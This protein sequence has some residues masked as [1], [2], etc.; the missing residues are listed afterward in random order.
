[1]EGEM[2]RF[3]GKVAVIT[4]AATGVGR[5]LAERSAKEGMKVV[6]ADIDK[7]ALNQTAKSLE[8]A[9]ADVLAVVTDVS[10]V[11]EV[12][13]LAKK[14]LDKFGAVH[15][16]C[17]TAAV[18]YLTPLTE[19]SLADW[20]W[21]IG[22]NL[23]GHIH[24]VAVFLPTMIMQDTECHIVNTAPVLGGFVALPFNGPYNVSEFGIVTLSEILSLELAAKKLKIGV[25]LLSPEYAD[26]AILASEQHR[27]AELRNAE[28][29]GPAGQA[30]P[31]FAMVASIIESSSRAETCPD[32]LA[33]IV[34]GAI[35]EN[36]FYVFPHPT[37][38]VIM[39]ERL[40]HIDQVT[41]PE[42]I[43]AL[44]GVVSQG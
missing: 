3:K 22:V 16:L 43:L 11:E 36:K 18:H 5:A 12:Q 20:K 14:T 24:T 35:R 8:A 32:H 31:D 28:V 10:N 42:N 13:A 21:V 39:R 30:S 41:N 27:P 6:L 23:Y 29:K 44:M 37:S 7:K 38:K 40:G 25:S 34:F 17:N 19:A 15:L 9:G 2:R 4:G 33:E 26:T 1:M